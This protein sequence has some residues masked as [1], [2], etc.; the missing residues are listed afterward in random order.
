MKA[1]GEFEA[2]NVSTVTDTEATIT[3]SEYG[4]WEVRVQGCNAAG[5]GPEAEQETTLVAL[6]GAVENL[7]ITTEP[8][9][10]D[11]L[12]R[13]DVVDGAT[14]YKLRWRQSGGDFKAGNAATVTG[15]T[16]FITVSGYDRW[17][18]R[19]QACNDA[20][21]GPEAGR[22]VDVVQELRSSLEEARDDGGN[23]RARTFTAN[24]DEVKDAA[25]YTL[26]WRRI[27]ANAPAQEQA[28]RNGAV[29]QARSG[30]SAQGADA[31][32]DNRIDF[33]AGQNSTDFDRAR[34]WRV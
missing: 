20:G 1:G 17:E 2:G 27:G 14:S 4:E 6:P 9:K 22:T 21:C 31:Q 3:V 19:V 11:L 28:Q 15:A 33:P 18:V 32:P 30:S 5:C 13:W 8:G 34:R 7:E 12:A 16:Q 23:D 25:S 10:L 24:W 29:R 26:R